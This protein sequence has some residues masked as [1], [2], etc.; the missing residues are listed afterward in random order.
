NSLLPNAHTRAKR[1]GIMRVLALAVA[2][3]PSTGA[4]APL[5]SSSM[6]VRNDGRAQNGVESVRYT[7]M[8]DAPAAATARA[9]TAPTD[10]LAALLSGAFEETVPMSAHNAIIEATERAMTEQVGLMAAA[11]VAALNEIRTELDAAILLRNADH[12]GKASLEAELKEMHLLV[13]CY[14]AAVDRVVFQMKAQK[15]EATATAASASARIAAVCDDVASL[16]QQLV[17]SRAAAAAAE[18]QAAQSRVAQLEAEQ[19]AGAAVATAAADVAAATERAG[20]AEAAEA[21]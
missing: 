13:D 4:F 18:A 7:A 11:A 16:Q 9:T 14:A 19:R 17:A 12:E 1:L 15:E 10:Q 6:H 5:G 8:I 20:R 3:L 2:L 21:H